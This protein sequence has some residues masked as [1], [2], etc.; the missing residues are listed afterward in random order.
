MDYS[1]LNSLYVIQTQVVG[2]DRHPF[3]KA[4]LFRPAWR[5]IFCNPRCFTDQ[6]HLIRDSSSYF[7]EVFR[8]EGSDS[9]KVLGEVEKDSSS[10]DEL[11]DDLSLPS[12]PFIRSLGSIC[13]NTR[14]IHAGTYYERQKL[15]LN[16]WRQGL[17]GDL[18]RDDEDED[19]SSW[20][21]GYDSTL[22]D[23]RM[24]Y[25]CFELARP[26]TLSAKTNSDVRANGKIFIHIYPCGY[27]VIHLAI[28]LAWDNAYS[29]SAIRET[30]LK[31]IRPHHISS[32]WM[33]MSRI[34][35]E[36]KNLNSLIKIIYREIKTSLFVDSEAKL[37]TSNQWRTFLRLTSEKTDSHKISRELLGSHSDPKV[38]EDLSFQYS[39][40]G[41]D[42]LIVTHQ[43]AACSF[44]PFSAEHLE[45]CKNYSSS[46]SNLI[47]RVRKQLAV[48]SLAEDEREKVKQIVIDA[49]P[50]LSKL[51][52]RPVNY[53][54]YQFKQDSYGLIWI[55]WEL[56]DKERSGSISSLEEARLHDLREL[57]DRVREVIDLVQSMHASWSRPQSA[58]RF[59]WKISRVQEFVL[60][61]EKIYEDYVCFMQNEIQKLK[62]YRRSLKSK[63]T[64]EEI[65]RIDVF[66]QKAA[67]FLQVLDRHVQQ[68]NDF[69]R[70]VYSVLCDGTKLNDNRNKVCDLLKEW[71]DEAQK[72]EHPAYAAWKKL[73]QPL[74]AI[75]SSTS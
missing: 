63:V 3:P 9:K 57:R 61:K 43:G 31:E 41:A 60:V 5:K 38:I 29:L 64:E 69:Y 73:V 32:K 33:W 40:S 17:E 37:D 44:R 6:R 21:L 47:D 42:K 65:F 62:K 70:F 18:T 28:S 23:Q 39:R 46:L 25:L 27:L 71:D 30:I 74:R 15:G 22:P 66:D 72:W 16:L 68:T 20:V 56:E 26:L 10:L 11:D 7:K 1:N 12:I 4:K 58:R 55:P 50:L 49:E 36:G 34:G 48:T 14:R 35:R 52:D 8:L 45:L 67:D 2:L 24:N 53:I 75:L 13:F 59:L 54:A 51:K 19:Q